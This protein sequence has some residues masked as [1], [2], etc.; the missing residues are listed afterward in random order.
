MPEGPWIRRDENGVV[1]TD[2]AFEEEG[3]IN[4]LSSI[5]EKEEQAVEMSNSSRRKD[6]EE[7]LSFEKKEHFRKKMKLDQD[8][9]NKL[10]NFIKKINNPNL[11]LTP[12]HV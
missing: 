9:E 11:R 1:F 12:V 8:V 3:S 2:L 6:D 4:F 10:N 5:G 7:L